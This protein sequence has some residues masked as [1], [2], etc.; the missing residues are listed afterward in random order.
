MTNRRTLKE[1]IKISGTG[2][3]NGG[4]C[5]LKILPSDDGGIVFFSR[6]EEIK[7]LPQNA[8]SS[9]RCT[10]LKGKSTQ[11]EVI[12]HVMSAFF[13]TGITDVRI[14]VVG[15]EVPFLD[16]SALPFV[17]AINGSGTKDTKNFR[18][19]YEEEMP[20]YVKKG[21]SEILFAPWREESLVI[22]VLIS[23]PEEGVNCEHLTFDAFS[24][25]LG[26]R[27]AGARTFAFE[28]WLDSLRERGLI[29]GGS[30][31]NALVVGKHGKLLEG[32]SFRVEDELCAHKA[33]DF[34]GDLMLF[35][36]KLRGRIFAFC[37]GHSLHLDFVQ[38]LSLSYNGRKEGKDA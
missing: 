9:R 29:N 34:L 14:E 17:E 11:I 37:P 15:E 21:F 35:P 10:A 25:D 5:S 8:D 12:E 38:K 31:E 18:D 4:K 24:K 1:T 2:L 26:T 27:I 33:L 32:C 13:I 30:L 7:A 36:K 6:G 3:H 22:T 16:G 28:S 23:F 20:V 19:E